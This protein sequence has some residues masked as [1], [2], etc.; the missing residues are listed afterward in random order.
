MLGRILISATVIAFILLVAIF[1]V[2]IPG[3]IGPLGILSVFILLYTIALGLVTFLIFGVSAFLRKT[4]NIFAA[5]KPMQPLTL[6]HSYY[7]ASVI[8]L[9]P[10]MLLGIHSVGELG[11]YD[12]LL[13][14]IFIVISLIYVAKR[15]R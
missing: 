9:G 7:F 10:I 8:S 5:K 12:V 3:N 6:T 2:T 4:I 1:Q 13:V 11:F 15:T 14:I